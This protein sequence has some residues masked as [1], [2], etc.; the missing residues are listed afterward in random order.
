MANVTGYF[1]MMSFVQGLATLAG[2][3]FGARDYATVGYNLQMA[4]MLSMAI[5]IFPISVLWLFSQYVFGL[6]GQE[7]GVSADA[8]RFLIII[9]PSVFTFAWRQVIQIW[10][11][12]QGI[13]RPFTV[14][15]LIAFVL[16]TPIT[17]IMVKAYGFIGGAWAQTII[18]T[19][20]FLMDSGYVT[21]SGVYK[22]TVRSNPRACEWPR[23]APHRV[24]VMVMVMW[25]RGEPRASCH[26]ARTTMCRS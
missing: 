14:S 20:Q 13:V 8:A 7:P 1:M 15:A 12:V 3:A 6:L 19:V 11:Q 23:L 21:C 25:Q 4:L 26:R 22:K 18:T 16:S 24:M 5:G 2:Q 17:F 10:C 9:I